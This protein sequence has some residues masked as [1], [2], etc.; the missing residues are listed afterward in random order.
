MNNVTLK[1]LN[2]FAAANGLTRAKGMLN[3]A[4]YWRSVNGRVISR[5]ALEDMFHGYA[6]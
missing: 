2:K 3:G 6:E 1:V 5:G 4:A